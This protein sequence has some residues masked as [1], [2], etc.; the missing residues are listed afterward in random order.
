MSALKRRCEA[1]TPRLARLPDRLRTER[2]A[3]RLPDGPV[4]PVRDP[5]P[6]EDMLSRVELAKPETLRFRDMK[7]VLGD[8]WTEAGC[9]RHEDDLLKEGIGRDRKT[10]DRAI[11]RSYLHQFPDRHDRFDALTAASR[12]VAGRRDWPWRERGEAWSL[13][14]PGDGPRKLA[15]ALLASDDPASILSAAGLTGELATGRY[16]ERAMEATYRVVMATRGAEAVTYGARLIDLSAAMKG[17]ALD[18]ML[19]L[20]LLAPW[21]DTA[22]PAVHQR[23]VGALLTSRI[24]DP[25]LSPAR[26]T[27][28]A[29]ELRAYGLGDGVEAAF[30]VLRRWL[31]QATV[32]EFFAVVAKTTDRPDQWKQRTDFWLGYLD[33]GHITD[34]WFAFGSAAEAQARRFLKDDSIGHARIEGAGA[35]ANQSALLMTLGD[36]RIAEWSD[37]G[38]CRFWPASRPKAPPMYRRV[39]YGRVLRSMDAER[40]Y[41]PI[42]HMGSTWPDRFAKRVYDRTGIRHPRHGAGW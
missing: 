9:E 21:V 22:P 29:A 20:A 12:Y 31:V 42:P 3:E 18:G 4:R 23:R 41:D 19:A 38:S 25:R 14:Q 37:N 26:W 5:E 11:V 27:A 16:V 39:Y 13:W 34:A 17:D 1:G 15:R 7:R 40:G 35:T 8:M 28:L 36:L 33:A 24:G 32:R 2:E 6:W 10:L 30:A